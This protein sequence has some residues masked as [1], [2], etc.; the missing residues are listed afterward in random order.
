M[1]AKETVLEAMKKEGQPVNA[2]K[3]TEITGLDRKE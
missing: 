1:D 3:I 2:G